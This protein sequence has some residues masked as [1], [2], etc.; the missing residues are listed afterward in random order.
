MKAMKKYVY[1][2]CYCHIDDDSPSFDHHFIEAEDHDDAYS[3]GHR[4]DLPSDWST[5][6]NDYVVE[7]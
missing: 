1:I 5:G 6:I 4:I 2:R 7:L 3:V